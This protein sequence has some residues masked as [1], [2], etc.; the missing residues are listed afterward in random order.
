MLLEKDR[1]GVRVLADSVSNGRALRSEFY[2][3]PIH[4]DYHHVALVSSPGKLHLDPL[5][6]S[7]PQCFIQELKNRSP[8]VVPL[9]NQNRP[10]RPHT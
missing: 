6:T 5:V 9:Q 7:R 1:A 3:P 8:Q 4:V 2:R 10:P